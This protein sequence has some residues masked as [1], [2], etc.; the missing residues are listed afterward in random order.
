MPSTRAT[1]SVAA[2]A[3][4]GLGIRMGATAYSTHPLGRP[5]VLRRGAGTLCGARGPAV[6][7]SQ[8]RRA[9]PFGVAEATEGFGAAAAATAAMAL[10]LV[11]AMP[12]R[13]H[14]TEAKRVYSLA[15]QVARFDRAKKE[16]NKRYLDITT[17][18][19]GSYLKGK[20]VLLVGGSRGLGLKI[21][22]ELVAQ[23][24]EVIATCRRSNPELDSAGATQIIPDVEVTSHASMTQMAS[25][26]VAPLDYVIFNAGYFPEVDDSLDSMQDKEAIMQIDVC[27]LGPLRCVSALKGSGLLSG[28][29][30]AIITSQAGSTE[31]RFTQNKD[32]GGDYGHHMSRAACNIGGALMSEELKASNV[33]IV[34]LHP[35]FNRTDMTA[36]FS[37]IWDVEG[38]VEASV[39]AKR[40]L[41]E[42][43]QISM[44]S[45][46]K[47]I[48]CEDGLLIPW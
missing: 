33:P 19:D 4:V 29:K 43:G 16:D 14:A 39:G 24:A 3:M 12:R 20:R 45:T 27:A 36:K 30:V 15:D 48:N 37:K 5:M 32:K 25:Q 6:S 8:G 21:V 17:I 34:M 1:R 38:A 23:G 35:G 31:W 7:T 47:F 9:L 13:A 22:Q 2:G 28:A 46:G 40:V 18:Y 42:V 11:L 26:I 44:E 10:G 41:H